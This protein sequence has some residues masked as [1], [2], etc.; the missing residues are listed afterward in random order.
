MASM[1]TGDTRDYHY[2]AV[3]LRRM[4]DKMNK[5]DRYLKLVRWAQDRYTTNGS[6]II[7]IGLNPS[8]Y[9]RIERAAAAK[10]L[11]MIKNS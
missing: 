1:T 8:T 5:Y 7:S 6:L 11:G 2:H 10:F 9:T 4:E 3:R